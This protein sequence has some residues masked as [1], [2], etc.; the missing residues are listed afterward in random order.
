MFSSRCGAISRRLRFVVSLSRVAMTERNGRRLSGASRRCKRFLQA[1]PNLSDCS[2]S[3]S[4]DSFGRLVGFQGI[5]GVQ[6]PGI[7]ILQIFAAPPG[8][9]GGGPRPSQWGSL[10]RH[11]STLTQIVFFRKKNR[12]CVFQ[13]RIAAA[14]PCPLPSPIGQREIVQLQTIFLNSLGEP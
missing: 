9:R 13:G 12:H 4:K 1:F 10:K 11:E 5:A 2:P 8:V 6:G 7:M 14:V 3:F